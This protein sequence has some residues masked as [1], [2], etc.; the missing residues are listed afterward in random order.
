MH[1]GMPSILS[2]WEKVLNL[3]SR[4]IEKEVPLIPKLCLLNVYQDNFVTSKNEKSLLN[5]C[6]LEA[7]R[8]IACSWKRDKPCTTSQ[9][10][11]GMSFYLALEKISYT[12][13]NKLDK[14][15]NVWKVYCN[16]LEKKDIEVDDWN[17]ELN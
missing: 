8:C 17:D 12:A 15:W 16:S 13:K 9:W 6:F 10:L 1:V 7:K 4:I 14:F 5:I 2:F 11:R 3:A